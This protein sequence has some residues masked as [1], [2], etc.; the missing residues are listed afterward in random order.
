MRPRI[1]DL[2]RPHI[3]DNLRD[4]E[5]VLTYDDITG[6]KS[7]VFFLSHNHM[8]DNVMDSKSKVI[9]FAESFILVFMRTAQPCAITREFM[10]TREDFHPQLFPIPVGTQL[11]C[12]H[13][14]ISQ[15]VGPRFLIPLSAS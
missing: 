8:E 7:N 15:A 12:P 3:Y 2:I 9:F 10:I 1:A 14:Q 5:S 4:H 6:V 13:V 11:P